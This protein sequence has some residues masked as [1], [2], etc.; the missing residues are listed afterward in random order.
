MDAT[1]VLA[2]LLREPL[3]IVDVGCRWGFADA[4]SQLGDSCT[5]IGFDPDSAECERLRHSYR[6]RAGMRLVPLGLGAEPGSA[7]LYMTEDPGGY[8]LFPGLA[9][10]VSRHPGLAGGR[11]IDTGQVEVT[12]LDNWLRGSDISRVDVVKIDTQGSELAILTGASCALES[13][14]A[15]E[16][17]VEFNELYKGVPL[18]G[19]IDAYLRERDF[20]LWRFKDLAHYAQAGVNRDWRAPEANYYDSGVARFESGSGQLFWANA[21]YLKR[22]VAYPDPAAGWEALARD[23]CITSALGFHDLTGQA[24]AHARLT[25]PDHLAGPLEAASSADLLEAWRR[26]RLGEEAQRLAG[27]LTVDAGDDLFHGS[28]WSPCQLT[29]TGPLRWTGP[30]REAS[31]ELPLRLEPGTTIELLVVAAMSPAILE[32]LRVE[33]NRTP[34]PLSRTVAE[35]G[36]LFSG[37]LPPGYRSDRQFVRLVL[38]TV[39]TIPWNE[40]DPASTD[41]TELGV[42]VSR[43]RLTAP[44]GH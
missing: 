42:A 27:S 9:D 12:T 24:L 37:V 30:A 16:V 1:S 5:I 15:V 26:R 40:T 32:N 18:F 31:I 43:V 22:A 2:D 44:A 35:G 29:D 28:G 11:V 13:T 23:A 8:S 36:V 10:L 6:G 33:V 20:V 25:A 21:F 17:E 38:R 3:V 41:D 4:W 39:E 7:T 19:E 34:V 14:R